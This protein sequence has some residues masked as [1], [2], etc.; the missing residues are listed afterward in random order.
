MITIEESLIL[1]KINS[2]FVDKLG[3]NSTAAPGL[4][5]RRVC[6]FLPSLLVVLLVP[7]EIHLLHGIAPFLGLLAAD[8]H[9]DTPDGR[10]Q[11]HVVGDFDAHLVTA[12]F[13]HILT[14]I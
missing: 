9:D 5:L 3:T 12:S 7:L 6:D 8:Y 11:H 2:L 1:G 14:T 13:H 10:R 4:V